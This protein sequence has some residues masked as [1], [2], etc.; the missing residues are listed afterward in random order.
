MNKRHVFHYFWTADPPEYNKLY[1]IPAATF[2]GLYGYS[3]MQS[4]SPDIHQM[5]YLASGL[6][7]VGALTG[8][9]SQSTARVGM[10]IWIMMPSTCSPTST[11]LIG[12]EQIKYVQIGGR[13]FIKVLRRGRTEKEV[14]DSE[15]V[16]AILVT[17]F[18]VS[19]SW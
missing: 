18:R 10:W 17:I 9:S 2:L 3:A 15:S 4:S 5:T 7:C 16:K 14:Q 13:R 8:L 12:K 6:C 19:K 1:G 11:V